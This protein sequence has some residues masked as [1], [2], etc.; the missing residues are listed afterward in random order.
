MIFRLD[1]VIGPLFCIRLPRVLCGQGLSGLRP[2]VSHWRKGS[3][4]EETG[5]SAPL[6]DFF[7][8]IFIRLREMKSS[9]IPAPLRNAG[10]VTTQRQSR[11]YIASQARIYRLF[12]FV[13]SA[14][15]SG[16][17]TLEGSANF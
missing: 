3:L 9:A 16:I 10:S 1:G 14:Y 8:L 4:I 5:T 15:A 17:T 2:M 12:G 6:A 13:I 7:S 11:R